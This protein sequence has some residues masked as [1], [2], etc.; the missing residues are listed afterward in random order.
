[1]SIAPRRKQVA[2][3]TRTQARP[4]TDSIYAL[5]TSDEREYTR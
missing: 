3:Y 2:R 1:M 5:R 4:Y